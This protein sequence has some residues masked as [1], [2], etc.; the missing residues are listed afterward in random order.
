MLFPTV[1]SNTQAI[2][3]WSKRLSNSTLANSSLKFGIIGGNAL[4]FRILTS[5]ISVSSSLSKISPFSGYSVL[6]SLLLLS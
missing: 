2:S 3:L 1:L 5:P 4:F 6:L